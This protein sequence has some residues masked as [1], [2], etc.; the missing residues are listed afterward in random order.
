MASSQKKSSVWID[1]CFNTIL[2]LL[3]A[4]FFY[5]VFINISFLNPFVKAFE[6]FD[7]TDLYYSKLQGKDKISS[8]IIL[9]NI[10]QAD[11]FEIAEAITIIEDEKP[12]V[13][14]LDIIFKELKSSYTDSILQHTLHRYSNIVL[15]YYYDENGVKK[16]SHEY[17]LN[18]SITQGFIN[19]NQVNNSQVV[20]T[21]TGKQNHENAFA[22]AVAQQANYFEQH[23]FPKELSSA[24]PINYTTTEEDFF[25]ITID[26]LLAKGNLPLAKD[27]VVLFGYLGT[28][29]G[30]VNDIEDKHFTPF[31][32]KIAGKSV[33][34]MYGVTIHA[35]LL[36][37]FKNNDYIYKIPNFFIWLL[38]L[39]LCF[40]GNILYFKILK[41]NEF[42]FDVFIKVLQFLFTAVWLYFSFLLIK[43]NVYLNV[44]IILIINL[45][46]M[47]VLD[48]YLHLINYLDKKGIWKSGVLH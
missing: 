26:E 25:T 47:E 30:N 9:V 39:L 20:R 41:K 48:F 45:L 36:K 43:S 16:Q 10:Q 23:S 31:N 22:V 27:A 37:M 8:D 18:P 6:D 14:G 1:A 17:F 4:G 7:F 24:I 32:S 42:V 33:P 29:T 35:N 46:S 15:G 5:V 44:S 40:F 21:F 28:P 19:L 3:V 12:T 11:R 2:T 38:T 34:D 13:I